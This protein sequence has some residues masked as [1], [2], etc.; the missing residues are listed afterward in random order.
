MTDDATIEDVRLLN[1][2][3]WP[4]P[5]FFL[6]A[7]TS[8]GLAE[9]PVLR[10]GI[11]ELANGLGAMPA[12]SGGLEAQ[13]GYYGDFNDPDHCFNY[14]VPPWPHLSEPQ[15]TKGW[16]WFLQATGAPR[17]ISAR[18]CAA[19]IRALQGTDDP[20][21]PLPRAGDNLAI[22]AEV[23]T[24]HRGK[25]RSVDLVLQW[26]RDDER[27]GVAVELKFGHVITPGQL[28]AYQ[29][30]MVRRIPVAQRRRLFVVA[31]ADD[32]WSTLSDYQRGEWSFVTWHN[33]M[34]RMELE[35][36]DAEPEFRRFRKLVWAR[37]LAG[38]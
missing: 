27:F 3:H 31:V 23:Q 24:S 19:F 29:A 30:E 34:R 37:S 17:L 9:L 28:P 20:V 5:E 11:L 16:Q 33:L 7:L 18:R 8:R 10:R 38:R 35:G 36:L 32:Q 1:S 22:A 4:D 26:G 14:P 15:V 2:L 12:W 6:D 13:R 21:F 25:K